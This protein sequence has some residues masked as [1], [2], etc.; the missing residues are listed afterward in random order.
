MASEAAEIG[1]RLKSVTDYVR[2]CQARVSKGELMDLQGLD[3]NVIAL[4]DAVA[5]LPE[6]EGQ[7]FEKQMS[8]LIESLEELANTIKE[9]EGL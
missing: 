3:K 2:D 8:Q 7:A 6:K 5:E 1:Q 4:C 9:R